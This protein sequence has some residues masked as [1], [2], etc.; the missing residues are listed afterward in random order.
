MKLYLAGP[1]QKHPEF[2]HPAFRRGAKLLRD[3]G[4]TVFS[5]AEHDNKVGLSTD[6]MTGDLAEIAAAG[7]SLRALLAADLAFISLE[8]DALVMLPGWEKSPGARAE[9]AVALAL[10]LPVWDLSR[11]LL[12]ESAAP[13]ICAVP[14]GVS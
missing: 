2:N 7:V 4:H 13:P 1:M 5:P 11:F 9:A 6:G 8:A 14:G 10:K 12:Y 3:L